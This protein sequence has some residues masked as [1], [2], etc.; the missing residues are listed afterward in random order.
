[1]TNNEIFDK[2]KSVIIDNLDI[3]EEKITMEA[4]LINDLEIDSL[5]LVDLT[6]NFEDELE[7]TIEDNELEKIKTVKDVVELVEKKLK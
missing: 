3:E 2:V 5:E 4:N 1:M 7:I 6:M